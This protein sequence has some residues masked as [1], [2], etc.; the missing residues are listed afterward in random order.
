MEKIYGMNELVGLQ[1]FWSG[2]PT[3]SSGTPT[4]CKMGV[5][6]SCFQN[7]SESSAQCHALASLF[8]N[9]PF[10]KSVCV[11]LLPDEPYFGC[12]PYSS[13]VRGSGYRELKLA[14]NI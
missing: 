3:F 4:F 5:L 14:L 11:I 13:I 1:L 10:S 6:N 9:M 12:L 8:L 2:T 7:P